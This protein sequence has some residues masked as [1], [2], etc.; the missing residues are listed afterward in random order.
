MPHDSDF[1]HVLLTELHD[2]MK[3]RGWKS[4]DALDL[5]NVIDARGSLPPDGTLGPLTSRLRA[6]NNGLWTLALLT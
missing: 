5:A 2:A 6:V 4:E 1:L 3:S